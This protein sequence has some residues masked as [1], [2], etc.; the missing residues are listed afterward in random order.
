MKKAMKILAWILGILVLVL[1]IAWFGFL[2]PE[3]PPISQADRA[4]VSLMPL[5]AELKLGKGAFVLDET[6][7]HQF[8]G[9][10]GPR[11]ERAAERFYAVIQPD[12]NSIE[13]E[14]HSRNL[15]VLAKL[16]LE[17]LN[18]PAALR[19]SEPMQEEFFRAASESQGA[20]IL[21]LA[22]PVQKLVQSA[23]SN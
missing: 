11:L 15:S 8:S 18:D 10:S 14:G 9:E 12:G 7:S 19:E 1:A 4:A 22:A 20:C 3:P 23:S 2:K 13:V 21:P 5:P 16:G 17:A 6:L